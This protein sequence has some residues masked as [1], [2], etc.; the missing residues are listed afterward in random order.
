MQP[1]PTF[2]EIWLHL[3]SPEVASGFV[4]AVEAACGLLRQ[5]LLNL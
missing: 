4:E 3:A 1:K 2:A 5:F